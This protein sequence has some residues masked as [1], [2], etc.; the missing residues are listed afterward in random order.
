V[1]VLVIVV[2]LIVIVIVIMSLLLHPH[3]LNNDRTCDASA[4]WVV[5]TPGSSSVND[6]DS[7]SDCVD[8]GDGDSDDRLRCNDNNGGSIVKV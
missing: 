5:T 2:V 3:A 4:R 1:K 6:S 7:V 8:N